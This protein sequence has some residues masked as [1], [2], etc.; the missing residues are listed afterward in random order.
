GRLGGEESV[1]A[2]GAAASDGGRIGGLGAGG[3]ASGMASRYDAARADAEA[4]LAN[5]GVQRAATDVNEQAAT[6]AALVD[7]RGWRPRARG[8]LAQLRAELGEPPTDL[9]ANP[10]LRA[11]R[12]ETAAAEARIE[13]ARRERY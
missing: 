11:A 13:L 12:D 7:A 8:S 10:A 5:L 3:G 9:A 6:L 4:A 1:G 2:G